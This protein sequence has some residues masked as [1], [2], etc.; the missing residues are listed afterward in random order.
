MGRW[1][2]VCTPLLRSCPC[3]V[4][5]TSRSSYLSLINLLPTDLVSFKVLSSLGFPLSSWQVSA[6]FP[7]YPITNNFF[8]PV[9]LC[10][11]RQAATSPS[12]HNRQRGSAKDKVL[13]LFQGYQIPTTLRHTILL[14][15]MCAAYT[16]VIDRHALPSDLKRGIHPSEK[17]DPSALKKR[18]DE[19]QKQL[20]AIGTQRADIRT[21]IYLA[22]PQVQKH[23][24]AGAKRKSDEWLPPWELRKRHVWFK[25]GGG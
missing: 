17:T 8:F 5:F 25:I 16:K 3:P 10:R 13:A 1:R 14:Y 21:S 20:L 19:D 12:V 22:F 7:S 24:Q 6:P 9:K 15:L 4:P 23:G 11:Y 18:G 2:P